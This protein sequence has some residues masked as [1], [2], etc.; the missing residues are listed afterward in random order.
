MHLYIATRGQKNLVDELINDLQAQYC[1]YK[2]NPHAPQPDLLQLG[3]RPL[4]VW[5]LAFPRDALGLVLTTLNGSEF[6]SSDGREIPNLLS[7]V[8][9]LKLLAGLKDI[10]KEY[11]KTKKFIVRK[12]PFVDIKLLGIKE[13]ADLKV[14]AV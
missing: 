1:L 11:D 5:E 3:V 10:P 2:A 12:S 13:D 4:Q 14:E 8:L 9:K 6:T 7:Y